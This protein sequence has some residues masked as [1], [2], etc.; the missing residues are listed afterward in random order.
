MLSSWRVFYGALLNGLHEF[1]NDPQATLITC[2]IWYSFEVL[3]T[4]CRIWY[5]FE[6]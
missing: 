1:H 4:A 5:L 6:V 3:A 2:Q